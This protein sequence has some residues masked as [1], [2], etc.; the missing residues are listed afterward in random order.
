MNKILKAGMA[1]PSANNCQPWHFLVI[2]DRKKMLDITK[3]QPFS[4]IFIGFPVEE[5]TPS[6]RY[7]SERVHYN[8]WRTK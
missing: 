2:N 7:I 3:I 4:L 5:K 1:A 6:N 8:F